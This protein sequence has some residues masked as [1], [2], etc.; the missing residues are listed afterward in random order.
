V[1]NRVH[2]YVTK[3]LSVWRVFVRRFT[4]YQPSLLNVSKLDMVTLATS[5][6]RY[7]GIWGVECPR[8]PVIFERTAQVRVAG[9]SKPNADSA[10]SKKEC[11]C[12]ELNTAQVHA[13][14]GGDLRHGVQS[15]LFHTKAST[16]LKNN[17]FPG[18]RWSSM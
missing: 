16:G 7:A 18:T 8:S 12:W 6:A 5:D 3:K 13:Q 10:R 4:G 9:A 15:C 17:V 2:T 11:G 1:F 14:P